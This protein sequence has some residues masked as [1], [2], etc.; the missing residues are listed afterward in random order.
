MRIPVSKFL[1]MA[2]LVFLQLSGVH[3]Y[4]QTVEVQKGMH[5][6]VSLS[7]EISTKTA[8]KGEE[9][10]AALAD[11]CIV[12]DRLVIPKGSIL[13]GSIVRAS[14]A[15]R[16]RG[17]AELALHFHKLELPTGESFSISASPVAAEG[18]SL[19][20]SSEGST[21][22]K[23]ADKHTAAKVAGATAAGAAVGAAVDGKKGAAVGAGI[24]IIAGIIGS[25]AAGG[26]DAVLEKGTGLEV[27]LDR[28]AWV[29]VRSV[30]R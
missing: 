29:P 26:K 25:S 24:G 22:G 13:R 4:S 8:E 12:D 23:S 15:G 7:Q 5:L 30:K 19:N 20:F 3:L 1:S 11:D 10:D 16:F 28:P 6:K 17:R 9:I 18:K 2:L 14:R 27:V 21:Q